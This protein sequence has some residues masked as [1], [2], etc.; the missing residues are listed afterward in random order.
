MF[1]LELPWDRQPQGPLRLDPAHPLARG[2]VVLLMPGIQP[3]NL[4]AGVAASAPATSRTVSA[5]GR[6]G[7]YSGQV[8]TAA[9]ALTADWSFVTA[10]QTGAIGDTSSNRYVVGRGGVGGDDTTGFGYAA[11]HSASAYSGAVHVGPAYDII[12]KPTGGPLADNTRYVVGASQTGAVGSVYSRGVKTGGATGLGT[13]HLGG[14]LQFGAATSGLSASADPHAWEFFALWNRALSD[15]EQQIAA[16]SAFWRIFAPR[17]LQIP[18]Y[19]A[20][21]SS[22]TISA[23]V[24]AAT[25]QGHQAAIALHTSVAAG[26]GAGTAQGHAVGIALRTVIASGVGDATAQ[27]HAATI[28]TTTQIAA[29]VGEA[30]AAGHQATITIGSGITVTCGTG[31]A[32]AQGH[33]AQIGAGT[34][35]ACGVGAAAATGH[36]V[37]VALRTVVS[38]GVAQAT[39]DGLAV[40]IVLRTTIAAGVGSATAAGHAATITATSSGSSAVD[41]WGYVLSNGK[42]ADQTVTEIHSMLSTLLGACPDKLTMIEKLLRNK[43]ITDPVA[44]T[45]T[46][47]DNDGSTVLAQ[48]LLFE[49]AAGTQAYRGQGAERA[50]RLA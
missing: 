23:G 16:S 5:G 31:A 7:R 33:A 28:S 40:G 48:G 24:G 10:F 49:D 9:A 3:G 8:S 42:T 15:R 44:G 1:E 38:G 18:V 45:Q 35:I 27:G 26:V 29:G 14:W 32:T 4:V 30:S 34:S 39:A 43:R 19:A 2:L 25:A 36:A 50:E 46:V 12:G 6:A 47:F 17:R 20:S 13:P 11:Y 22:T 21:A 41:V 37:D